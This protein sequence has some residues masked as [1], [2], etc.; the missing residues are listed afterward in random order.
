MIILE[1]ASKYY[2]DNWFIASR[3]IFLECFGANKYARNK[4]KKNRV[5][6][7][8]NISEKFYGGKNVSIIFPPRGGKTIFSKILSG[9]TSLDSGRVSISGS[10]ALHNSATTGFRAML[11]LEENIRYYGMFMGLDALEQKELFIKIYDHIGNGKVLNKPIYNIDRDIITEVRNELLVHVRKENNIYD[12]VKIINKENF[13]KNITENS[14]LNIFLCDRNCPSLDFA[15]D[16]YF[17]DGGSLKGPI[18]SDLV[19]SLKENLDIEISEIEQNFYDFRK[20]YVENDECS[21]IN[22]KVNEFKS[23]KDSIRILS[24]VIN[25]VE[26]KKISEITFIKKQNEN[27]SIELLVAFSEE[28]RFDYVVFALTASFDRQPIQ[29]SSIKLSDFLNRDGELD[30]FVEG[31]GLK[32]L[33]TI[34]FG[35]LPKERFG[36][37]MFFLRTQDTDLDRAHRLKIAEVYTYDSIFQGNRPVFEV[38]SFDAQKL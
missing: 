5:L 36:L 15:D 19:V 10:V 6:V 9:M 1:N 34:N 18:S 25:G 3:S 22:I 37:N 35:I 13:S 32:I 29:V 16:V 17:M 27:F 4:Y 20:E 2:Y 31:E 28:R 38:V 21:K 14:E 33:A 8:E 11:T 23:K 7:L 24:S 26:N 30:K 12:S